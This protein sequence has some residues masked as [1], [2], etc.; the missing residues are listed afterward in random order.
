[1]SKVILSYKGSSTSGN[2]AHAGRV[3]KVGG[4]MPRNYGAAS[5]AF[6]SLITAG[7]TLPGVD[8]DKLN[9]TG[10]QAI[11]DLQAGSINWAAAQAIIA[12][13]KSQKTVNPVT[14]PAATPAAPV[15]P[16]PTPTP[17]TPAGTVIL[18]PPY[19]PTAAETQS[20]QDILA[21]LQDPNNPRGAVHSAWAQGIDPNNLTPQ[22]IKVLNI[23]AAGG[24][25]GATLKTAMAQHATPPATATAQPAAPQPTV[26][27]AQAMLRQ[28]QGSDSSAW[29]AKNVDAS[30]L[31]PDQVKALHE[32]K[33]GLITQD[34]LQNRLGQSGAVKTTDPRFYQKDL[35]D[36]SA[37]EIFKGSSKEMQDL[38]LKTGILP[39]DQKTLDYVQSHTSTFERQPKYIADY[40][41]NTRTPPDA[42]VQVDS[43]VKQMDSTYFSVSD[44][45]NY[46]LATLQFRGSAAYPKL[47]P[48]EQAVVDKMVASNQ[49]ASDLYRNHYNKTYDYTTANQ[50]QRSASKQDWDALT[51]QEKQT[52][53]S[54][55]QRAEVQEWVNSNVPKTLF[56]AKDRWEPIS[57]DKVPAGITSPADIRRFG[58]EYRNSFLK[59]PSPLPTTGYKPHE[60][61][62]LSTL[63]PRVESQVKGNFDNT[64]D[65]VNHSR[66]GAQFNSAFEIHPQK[67]VLD[68]FD[69]AKSARDNVQTL[70]HG[71]DYE[72]ARNIASTGYV[73]KPASQAKVGRSMGDGVYF[74]DKSSKGCQYLGP[75]FTRAPGTSGVLFVNE[76][77]LGKVVDQNA[78]WV[79]K[80]GA[81]TIFGGVDRWVNK[82]WSVMDPKAMLPSIWIDATLT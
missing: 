10:L 25:R 52:A 40:E 4:S 20:A 53:V 11:I 27:D 34:E 17:A 51:A 82:E 9:R 56:A 23:Y 32:Y 7:W 61:V 55:L 24:M 39:T 60:V 26:A 12:D 68:D 31:T 64:W 19:V 35:T 14:M 38:A 72:A 29:W 28:V 74:C 6:S 65:K 33:T 54:L 67:K 44:C 1:M 37:E 58:Y 73:V 46:K 16:T 22:Q 76:V 36:K 48:S 75:S 70:Y 78:S 69:A 62:A 18:T 43:Y 59:R 57:I 79:D 50:L 2:Y 71:T 13:P 30:K 49:R 5:T 80:Q 45:P 77:S 3:G 63:N 15:T 21:I 47:T 41:N 8:L 42:K 81:N 66:F